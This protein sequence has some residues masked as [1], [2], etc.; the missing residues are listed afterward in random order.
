MIHLHAKRSN[1]KYGNYII[2]DKWIAKEV[3][4]VEKAEHVLG[5]RIVYVNK[6][7]NVTISYDS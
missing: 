1:E 2:K 7:N 3:D 4:Y 6:F 5:N